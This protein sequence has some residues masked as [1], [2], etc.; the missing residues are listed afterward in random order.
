ML[1]IGN[2]Q[3]G[4]AG[5]ISAVAENGSCPSCPE[6]A[7]RVL[8]TRC[9]RGQLSSTSVCVGSALGKEFCAS[10]HRQVTCALFLQA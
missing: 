9:L 2:P 5:R 6:G 4:P 10:Y 7:G 3:A 8:G 1:V